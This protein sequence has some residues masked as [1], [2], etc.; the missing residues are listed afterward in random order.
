M[1]TLW[2]LDL[3]NTLSSLSVYAIGT[4][5]LLI[6]YLKIIPWMDSPGWSVLLK[7]KVRRIPQGLFHFWKLQPV[8]LQKAH[9]KLRLFLE[10]SVVVIILTDILSE[11]IY[12]PLW[13]EGIVDAIFVFRQI[14]NGAHVTSYMTVFV[15]VILA[16]MRWDDSLKALLYGGLMVFVHEGLWFPFYYA[17]NWG[18]L[19]IPLDIA[20]AVWIGAMGYVGWK[21]YHMKVW[22]S[23]VGIYF[24]FLMSWFSL[25]F[26]ITVKNISYQAIF[27]KTQWYG[28]FQAESNEVVSW[29]LI[30]SVF[31]YGLV[32]LNGKGWKFFEHLRLNSQ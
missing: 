17:S 9:I 23:G 4:V 30:F 22:W 28:N 32:K 5:C 16:S 25:G 3:T 24:G 13:K 1:V 26:P 12:P 21:K 8:A 31:V 29:L 18:S 6:F 20:F 19:N 15:I 7:L 14:P 2:S 10:A 11:L 27:Y